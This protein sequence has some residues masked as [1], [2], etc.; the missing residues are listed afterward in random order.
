M[1]DPYL[2]L[3]DVA[4]D[5]SLAWA[6]EQNKR[7]QTEL[8]AVTGFDATRARILAILDSK[9]KI[10]WQTKRATH[11]YNFWQDDAHPRGLWRRTTLAEYRKPDP[12]WE[13]LLDIDAL[14][15]AENES[16]VWGGAD[17]LYP[18]YENCLI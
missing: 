1:D 9:D 4:G 11:L 2:W 12:A 7:S 15:K 17:C 16:W 5:K 8:E 13:I 10:P 3:E 6:R 18:K 14:N